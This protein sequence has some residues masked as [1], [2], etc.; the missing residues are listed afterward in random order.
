MTIMKFMELIIIKEDYFLVK[1]EIQV[2]E[3]KNYK[4]GFLILN[5]L[6][7]ILEIDLKY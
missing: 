7:L 2:K 6:T 3:K 4:K 1:M 5:M